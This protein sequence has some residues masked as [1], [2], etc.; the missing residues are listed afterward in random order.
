[1]DF[2]PHSGR[3]LLV[4]AGPGAADLLTL[5]AVRA[6][7]AADVVVHDGLVG[8]EVMALIP[9]HARRIS[10]AKRRARHTLA[11]D[12]LRRRVGQHFG[13]SIKPGAFHDARL[14]GRSLT[15]NEKG[16]P[17]QAALLVV[18]LPVQA[19]FGAES[20]TLA[21]TWASNWAK[22]AMNMPT[23]ALALAS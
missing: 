22:L 17:L 18:G 8:D 21:S 5:R 2:Y 7:A 19:A 9:A 6:L 1:M 3:I 12:Q 11:Q 10:V 4:G 15:R 23:S 14:P 16:R 20:R 13:W